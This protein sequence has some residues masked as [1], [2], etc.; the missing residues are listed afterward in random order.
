[1]VTSEHLTLLKPRTYTPLQASLDAFLLSKQAARCSAKTLV[2]YRYTVGNFVA[3]P[4]RQHVTIPEQITPNH[5]R[6]SLVDLQGRGLKDSTQHAHA[7]GIKTWLRRLAREGE[8]GERR[9]KRVD[10]PKLEQRIPAPFSL[11]DISKLLDACDRKPDLGPR[12]YAIILCLLDSG[13]R[14]AEF[15][16]L[17]QMEV[18]LR[19]GIVTVR[20]RKRRKHRQTRFGTK[21]RGALARFLVAH[22]R[23]PSQP[24][25]GLT[26]GGM[27]IMLYRLGKGIDVLP[28]GPHRLRTFA[29]WCLREGM[30][31]HGLRMLMGHSDLSILQRYLAL[32]GE[33]IER[34]HMAHSPGDRLLGGVTHNQMCTS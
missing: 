18:N 12:N 24:L 20:R 29:L 21:H 25:W 32:T 14:L 6:R 4:R 34:A 7:R 11:Q 19:S 1:M 26:A 2:H 30:D 10:T 16:S 15:A 22:H 33:D 8:L 27:Q 13:L 28:C 31:L 23:K 17:R 3:F 5:I 9:V